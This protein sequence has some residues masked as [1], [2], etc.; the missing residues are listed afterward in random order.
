MALPSRDQLAARLKSWTARANT[1]L[2]T[3]ADRVQAHPAYHWIRKHWLATS[4]A[5][6]AAVVVLAFAFA[7]TCGFRKCPSTE[8]LQ[9]YEPREGSPVL[10]RE[11]AML[12]RLQYVRRVNI[13]LDTVPQV[14]RDAFLAVED[15]R[16]YDHGGI[17]LRSAVRAVFA[18]VREMG[19]AEGF[20]T[21][22]MQ[23]VRNAFIP[24]MALQ[25]TLRRKLIELALARKLEQNLSKDKIL[26]LY[27]NVIYL[28]NGVYGVEAASRDLFGKGVGRLSLEEAA[29]LAA[30]PKGPSS[31]NPR[32]HPERALAR[33]NLV[34]SLMEQQGRVTPE[35]AREARARPLKIEEKGW[36]P[37][38][39][40][41]DALDPIRAAV[42]SL[43]GDDTDGMADVVVHTTIDA[44]AQQAAARAVRTQAARIE[45]NAEAG[46]RRD[47]S[48]QGAMVALDPRTGEIRALVNG[49]TYERGGFSRALSARRQPGSAFKPF[50]YGAA[51]AQGYSPAMV[52]DDSPVE[53]ELVTGET[54]EPDNYGGEYSGQLT[55]RRALML[56]ANAATIRLA[57]QVGLSS[58]I[59][60]AERMGI[61]SGLPHVPALALGAAEVTP[62]EL[63]AAYAP[64]A[65]G[66]YRIAPSL[67]SSIT[68]GDGT[69]VWERDSQVHESILD[70]REAFQITSMLQTVVQH[71]TGFEVRRAG[72]RDS[73]AGKTGTTNEGNDVWFVGYTPSLVTGFWFGYDTPMSLG[74]NASGGR[75][76]APA[77]AD[78]YR[79]GWQG[80]TNAHWDP[81]PGLIMKVIDSYNGELANQ[82]CP[83]TQREWFKSGTEPTRYCDDHQASLWETLEGIGGA[84]GKAIKD[85]LGF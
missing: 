1:R 5:I 21:I 62:L 40:Q 2:D 29:T 22:T 50:V 4:A 32:R 39:D 44:R 41:I 42:D 76:A 79:R 25:R 3:W 63:V 71:G 16:F 70:P 18:N 77:F 75:L 46:R 10:D 58:V 13:P 30:L 17:D 33:R 47:A 8:S 74:A 27:L 72:V 66:G 9:R 73:I 48:V 61:R 69:P 82:Y 49:S 55:M 15:R 52:L 37:E 43:L 65:N 6:A 81:P 7:T 19:V 80:G 53:I 31:Y 57:E 11:G 83:V 54:W 28:G 56:S 60:Y 45:R 78:F 24:E 84:F 68:R 67:I 51:L 23:V 59:S 26:E 64:F 38:S 20:S 34:I 85:L 14:V 36:Y 35:A 12:G